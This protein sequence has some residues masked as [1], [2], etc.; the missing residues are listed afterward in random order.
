MTTSEGVMVGVME[1]LMPLLVR[2]KESLQL[3][4]GRELLLLLYKKILKPVELKRYER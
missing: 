2:W 1:G 3:G 4:P